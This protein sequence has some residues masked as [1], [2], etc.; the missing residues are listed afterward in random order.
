MLFVQPTGP[1]ENNC[2]VTCDCDLSEDERSLM[3]A[4]W[5]KM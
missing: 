2:A 1:Y 3:Q 5:L 4:R